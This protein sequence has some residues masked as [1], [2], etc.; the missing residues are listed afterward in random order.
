MSL[1]IE[2]CAALAR[3]DPERRSAA[4]RLQEQLGPELAQ[5]LVAALA[6]RPRLAA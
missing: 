6:T 1:L 3:L 5:L 4:E 2:H